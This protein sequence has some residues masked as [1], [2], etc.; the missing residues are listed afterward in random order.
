MTR[1]NII[2]DKLEKP[3]QADLSRPLTIFEQIRENN[4][5]RKALV[6][7]VILLVWEMMSRLANVPL[8]LP[9]VP[10]T[11]EALRAAAID[12]SPPLFEH[13]AET[14]QALGAG[15][16]SGAGIAMILTII[17]INSRIGQDFLETIVGAFAP[18]PAVAVFPIALMVFGISMKT[19]I[20]I[21]GF[22]AVFPVAL[23][24]FAG[25]RGVSQTLR[26]VG[27]NIGLSGIS[28]V[29]RI[30]VPAALPSIL[31]G[32]RNG[33]SNGL[34]ALLAV[35]FV[36]GAASGGVGGL[37]WMVLSAKQDLNTPMVYAGIMA[38]MIIGLSFELL[39][40]AIEKTTVR[41]WGMLK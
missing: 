41:K 39:F 5:V 36:I 10:D 29:V 25:F 15:F 11:L 21:A 2:F 31:T 3:D 12:G 19:A 14:M 34:R 26:D 24:T 27:H 20:F 8:I 1:A 7:V 38:I 16:L 35:E 13:L 4:L 28:F 17:A 9:S 37:G 30:L 23:G 6:V 40:G 18:L 33:W 22:A 32:L